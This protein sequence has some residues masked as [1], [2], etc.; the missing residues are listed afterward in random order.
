MGVHG[1]NLPTIF[2]YE[3]CVMTVVQY[4]MTLSGGYKGVEMFL[5]SSKFD[6]T[7]PVSLM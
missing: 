5:G 1:M 2:L 3:C 7:E 4:H 6:L